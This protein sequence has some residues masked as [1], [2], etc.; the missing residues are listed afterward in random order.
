[1]PEW[2]RQRAALSPQR[3]ALI[4]EDERWTF[5]ELDR[6]ISASAERLAAVGVGEGDHV[7]LLAQNGRRF[8][9]VAHAVTRLG[10]VLLPLNVR[11]TASEL[12]W[13]VRDGG[14]PLLVYDEASAAK[15][16]SAREVLSGLP[17]VPL[18]EVTNG[19]GGGASGEDAFGVRHINL[20]SVHTIV[21]TSG[22]T[23]RPK[24]A[25]LTYGNHLWSAVGSA[26]NLGLHSDDRWLACLPLFHVGGLAILLR[27]LIYGITA[28]VHESF[29]AEAVNRAI[30]EDGVTIVSV[31]SNMLQRMLAA[32]GEGP[33]PPTLRCVL[34]G[35]GPVP[36]P[37]LEECTRRGVPVAH[38]YGLTEAASQVATLAPEEAVSKLGSGGKPLFSTE[39]RIQGDDGRPLPPG[40]PGEIVV[41]GPTVTPGYLNRQEETEQAL[42]DGWLHTGDIGYLDEEGYLYVLDRRHDLIVSGGENVYPAE[43]ESVLQSHPAVL[44]AGVTGLPDQRWGQTAAAAVRL[45]PGAAVSEGELLAFCRSRLAPFKVPTRM[46]FASTLPRNAAGKL[47]REALRREWLSQPPSAP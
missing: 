26:L 5:V 46:R 44:E 31:V 45:H 18:T 47:L 29:D 11:L 21:Y 43:V 10:A 36:R 15:V 2:L 33:Y 20:S 32:R 12:S 27:S 41:R 24:G 9:Q 22:T 28:V 4:F 34:V 3:L 13:Q 42:R 40:K 16:A 19:D 1:M 30:D 39:V 6:L 25:M 37:L 7:A 23:G 35:G 38:T 14:A 8:V 17:C